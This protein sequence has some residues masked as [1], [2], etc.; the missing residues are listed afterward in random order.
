MS[1]QI[2]IFSKAAPNSSPLVL[3]LIST[4]VLLYIVCSNNICLKS[5]V[6]IHHITIQFLVLFPL[7]LMQMTKDCLLMDFNL[8]LAIRLVN[9][10]HHGS[11][12]LGSYSVQKS[13][14]K[15]NVNYD[16]YRSKK[17]CYICNEHLILI[18][19]VFKKASDWA[20]RDVVS[21]SAL[22][23]GHNDQVI[24]VLLFHS[25]QYWFAMHIKLNPEHS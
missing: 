9:S 20:T 7:N 5:L 6:I 24:C 23:S 17:V 22:Y 21:F 14:S 25:L 8:T 10:E 15:F 16:V 1:K 3:Q 12:P 19:Y 18:S 2:K 13:W 11:I 4:K